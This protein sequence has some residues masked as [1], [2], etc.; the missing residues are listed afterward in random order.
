M[1]NAHYV[2]S[3]DLLQKMYQ[4]ERDFD[5]FKVELATVQEEVTRLLGTSITITTG[6]SEG[7]KL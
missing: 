6:E 1:S 3:L 2:S 7:G 5:K 4:L